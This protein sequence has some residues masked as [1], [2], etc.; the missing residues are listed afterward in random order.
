MKL[1]LG[2]ISLLLLHLQAG[3]TRL[4]DIFS[5]ISKVLGGF[6][7]CY[8]LEIKC[9]FKHFFSFKIVLLKWWRHTCCLQFQWYVEKP[10][11]DIAEAEC[12]A[13]CL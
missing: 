8:D 3:D 9:T 1:Q 11:S 6:C 7:L 4:N 12:V 2:M 10:I 5:N 13:R